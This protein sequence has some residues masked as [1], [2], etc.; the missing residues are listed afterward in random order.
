MTTRVFIVVTPNV[1]L[2]DLAGPAEALRLAQ[3]AGAPL[4]LHLAGPVPEVTTS[5]GLPLGALEPLPEALEPGDVVM[6]VGCEDS[7]RHYA[8]PE[9]GRVVSWLRRLP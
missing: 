9:A 6:V 3:R 4:A 5:I 7:A 8:R 2:L 1:L